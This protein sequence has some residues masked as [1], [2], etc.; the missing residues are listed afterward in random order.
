MFTTN[1]K[2]NIIAEF[3]LLPNDEEKKRFK[4][5]D[6][7]THTFSTD[8]VL[9]LINKGGLA[10]Q[11]NFTFETRTKNVFEYKATGQ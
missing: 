5:R 2:T 11:Y 7:E 4:E 3:L 9:D 6:V 8:L 1:P 10:F